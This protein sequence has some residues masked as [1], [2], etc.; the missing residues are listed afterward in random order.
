MAGSRH[1]SGLR[2]LLW[3]KNAGAGRRLLN[4]KLILRQNQRFEFA[5]AADQF[6]GSTRAA[7]I[8]SSR[9]PISEPPRAGLVKAGRVFRG[10]PKGTALIG[11][12]RG[13]NLDRIGLQALAESSQFQT[14]GFNTNSHRW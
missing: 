6:F 7:S 14:A 1:T 5:V 9:P 11:P 13:G 8:L 10:H 2:H 12:A 4:S 3:Q